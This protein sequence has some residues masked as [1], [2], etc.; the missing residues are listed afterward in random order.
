MPPSLK[1]SINQAYLAN[2]TYDKIIK[3][4][5]LEMELNAIEQSDDLPVT[6]M[7]ATSKQPSKRDG[8]KPLDPAIKKKRC[9]YCKKGGHI[10]D[11]CYKLR[12][13]RERKQSFDTPQRPKCD[14]CN[15]TGHTAEKCYHN[16]NRENK[17]KEPKL[18]KQDNTKQNQA[19]NN[20][21][22]KL[23]LKQSSQDLK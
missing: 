16:P 12:K 18:D 11:D 4:I 8:K 17:P 6:T 9:N 5:E 20:T 19:A 3:H 14:Y 21:Q 1:K 23:A 15:K 13:K 22:S 2:C 10:R 7:T